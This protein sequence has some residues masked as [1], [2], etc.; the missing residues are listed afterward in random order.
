M[1][2][3]RYCKNS[4]SFCG[5]PE[6]MAPEMLL[7]SG[8][9]FKLDI[10]CLGALLYELITGLPPFYSRN[11]DEIYQRILNQKLSFPS[12]IKISVQLKD[13]LNSLL[14]KNPKNR[15]SDMNGILQ[16]PWSMM[17]IEMDSLE[18]I[19][20][21]LVKPPFI[22]DPYNFN[23]DEEEFGQG[24]PEFLIAMRAIQQ[25]QVENYPK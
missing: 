2:R 9:S 25:Q 18:S 5:S 8:H 24:E 6:Y 17:Y 11:T 20:Q 10:Y 23:F 19:E 21:K 1:W 14:V 15:I 4:Y 16:H 7:K 13:L 22:P 12:T 3:I